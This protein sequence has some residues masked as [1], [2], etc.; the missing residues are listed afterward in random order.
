MLFKY[1]N[2]WNRD[3][4]LDLVDSWV[5]T[6]RQIYWRKE[7]TTDLFTNLCCSEELNYEGRGST[8]PTKNLQNVMVTIYGSLLIDSFFSQSS[9]I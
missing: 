4:E 8:S 3:K 5:T 7:E 6:D 1:E 9:A 2:H